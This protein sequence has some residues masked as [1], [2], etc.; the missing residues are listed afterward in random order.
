MAISVHWPTQVINI[1]KAD[2][3]FVSGVLYELNVNILRLALKALEDDEVG[4][5]WPTTHNHNTEITLSGV[6][7]A[8]SVEIINGYTVRFEDGQYV[9]KCA[10]A[11]HNLA[12]VKVPNQVSIIIGNSAGLVV[13]SGGGS[14]GTA[15]LANQEL[16][17]DRLTEERADLLDKLDIGDGTALVIPSEQPALAPCRV[18]GYV[19]T[20]D[21]RS[22]V[23]VSIKFE[24]ISGSAVLSG[25]MVAIRK[26]VARTD[27]RGRVV[28]DGNLWV[29]LQ[30]TDTMIPAGAK[31]LIT[32]PTLK[33][34]ALVPLE[35]E[36]FD[37][38][39]LI[40]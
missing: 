12:D 23:G 21:G 19:K 17:L 7:Y 2:L 3:T 22:A 5:A 20:I 38:A 24:L 18:F 31:Y 4:Q 6:T 14:S 26:V 29:D 10:G 37:L 25:S 27:T 40:P 16:L 30:R 33:L 35:T 13:I 36:M 15:T 39:S 34:R 11:N 9:V 28:S 8:R 32:C 1:P